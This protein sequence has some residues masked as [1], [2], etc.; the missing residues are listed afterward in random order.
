VINRPLTSPAVTNGTGDAMITVPDILSFLRRSLFVIVIFFVAGTFA[1]AFYAFSSDPIYT[2]RTQILIEPNLPQHLQQQQEVVTSLDTA[3]V[4]TQIAVMRSEKIGEMV[5]DDLDLM[6]NPDFFR[7]SGLSFADRVDRFFAA[8]LRKLGFR[9][10][11]APARVVEPASGI[12]SG[13]AAEPNEFERDRVAI[14]LFQG[15][16]EIR[17]V[18]VSYA[19]DIFFRS[20]DPELAANIANATAQMF[21][22]E[23]LE[24]KAAAAQAGGEWLERRLGEMKSRMNEA[25]QIAQEFRARH[26][27]R[28][29][30]PASDTMGVR[31]AQGT[32]LEELEVTADT[33]RKMYESFLVA[34]TNNVSN[35]SYPGADARVITAATRPLSA[36]HPRKKLILAFGMLSGIVVGASIGFLRHLF[37]GSLRSPRQIHE[38]L[39]LRCLAELPAQPGR[40]DGFGALDAVAATP[41]TWFSESLRRVKAALGTGPKPLRLIGVTSAQP[42]EGKE[43]VACNLALLYA[44]AGL[45]TALLDADADEQPLAQA[46]SD[47]SDRPA[48]SQEPCQGVSRPTRIVRNAFGDVDL[49]PAKLSRLLLGSELPDLEEYEM[50]VVNLPPLEAGADRL[51]MAGALDGNLIVSECGKTPV[52]LVQE[53]VAILHAHNA[54]VLGLLLTKVKS[55]STTPYLREERSWTRM[56]SVRQILPAQFWR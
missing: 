3:Q 32:T 16:L 22:R 5:I 20:R 44:R 55:P 12:G 33:Y 21:I 54:P 1:A 49:L 36:S 2:A 30:Q 8:I 51:M 7:I 39:G 15:A 50:V 46:I 10:D 13:G 19:V 27:Y 41:F 31:L 26:D 34:Y 28:V 23:Q 25:T 14:A 52:D 42:H 4:E 9:T 17:R 24:T 47:R 6:N 48:A 53:L 45:R 40:N 35:Q 43:T 29:Q 56:G 38:E 37:D 11:E 18:G